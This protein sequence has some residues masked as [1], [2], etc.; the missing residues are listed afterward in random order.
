M[1][2]SWKAVLLRAVQ[3]GADWLMWFQRNARTLLATG[4]EVIPV[5]FREERKCF[6]S[7]F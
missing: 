7:I 6:L 4:L 5:I 1:A 2:G 3:K